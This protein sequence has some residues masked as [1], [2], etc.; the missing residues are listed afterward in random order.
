MGIEDFN[1]KVPSFFIKE[2]HLC[3]EHI[4]Q[5]KGSA[6]KSMVFAKGWRPKMAARSWQ[7]AAQ[8]VEL[9]YQHK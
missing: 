3:L 9:N 7:D 4:N 2:V 6:Q 5:R 1:F 8:R